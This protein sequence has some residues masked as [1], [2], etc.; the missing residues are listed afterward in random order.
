MDNHS[1]KV[2]DLK[3]RKS[4]EKDLSAIHRLLGE[5]GYPDL[6]RD[7][8]R[9]VFSEISDRTDMGIFVAEGTNNDIAGFVSYSY[10]PQLRVT[11]N[12]FEVDEIVVSSKSRGSGVGKLLLDFALEKAKAANAR[13]VI[14]STSRDRE[15]YKRRFYMKNGFD[16]KNSALMMLKL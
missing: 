11:G 2:Q 12:L 5:L 3:I 4:E 15:S 8:L 16:E 14:L 1:S 7:K 13:F 6:D 9:S 10:K